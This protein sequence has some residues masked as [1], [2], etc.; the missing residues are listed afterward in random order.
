M[1]RQYSGKTRLLLPE[2]QYVTQINQI[3]LCLPRNI[4]Y[5]RNQRWQSNPESVDFHEL[6]RIRIRNLSADSTDSCM[7]SKPG[8]HDI[9]VQI[10]NFL[11]H[12]WK[13]NFTQFY[14]LLYFSVL[15]T[16][17]YSQHY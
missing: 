12:N 1:R 11:Y 7:I 10:L 15:G 8:I 4:I 16:Y 3:F 13:K 2:L 9:S 14:F 17:A 6:S 5:Y